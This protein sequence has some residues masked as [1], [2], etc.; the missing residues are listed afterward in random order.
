M[1]LSNSR[2]QWP[3]EDI[4]MLLDL[5]KNILPSNDNHTFKTTQSHM[6]WGKVAFKGYSGEMC[7][8]KWLEISS[9]IRKYRTLTELILEAK[10]LVK[11]SYK[12]KKL[13][14]HPDMP[15]KPLTPY[16]RFFKE[17]RPLYSQM[18]PKLKNQELTK[19][20]SEKYKELPE[21]MKM[22][23]IQDFQKEKQEF[24]EKLAQFRK[25]CSELV[26]N[27]KPSVVHKRN[28]NKAP[29]KF[30]R[31]G[32]EVK[33]SQKNYF[34]EFKSHGEPK[35][36]PMNE[37][38]KFHQDLW[39]S[40][41]LQGLPQ[42]ERMMEISRRWQHI[43]RSQ[44][45]HYRKQAEELQKQYKVDLEHWLKSLSPEEYAAYRERT[46]GKR[47]NTNMFGGPDPKII[48]TDVQ[49]PPAQTL[50]GGLTQNQGP[51]APRMASSETNRDCP[52]CSWGSEEKKEHGGKA[53]SSSSSD[54]SSSDEDDS[55]ST[56]SSSGDT[57]DSDSN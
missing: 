45:E 44:K 43:P 11:N 14:N 57:S 18:Y 5:M 37:F 13:K 32:K 15:K 33:S 25:D 50:P 53:E 21:E 23:Y 52:H 54:P 55:S 36:P 38:Q 10:E 1:A 27:S 17:K 47:K 46:S 8:R 29:K 26:Q 12:S 42:R 34:S 48:R 24:Q 51:R 9:K 56:S 28:P 39:W 22:K 30:Q 40:R 6:D 2:D 41:E 7:K 49:S 16:L 31:K 35:K 20:M 19:V 4:V 3:K